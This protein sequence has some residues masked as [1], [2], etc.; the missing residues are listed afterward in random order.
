MARHFDLA[1]RIGALALALTVS[2]PAEAGGIRTTSG[3]RSGHLSSHQG[4][5]I[6]GRHA[7][8]LPNGVRIF[9]RASRAAPSRHGAVKPAPAKGRTGHA[10]THGRRDANARGGHRAPAGS[11]SGTGRGRSMQARADGVHGTGKRGKAK[12]GKHGNKHRHGHKGHR[13]KPVVYASTVQILDAG[14][15]PAYRETAEGD[16][17]R[18]LTDRGYDRA[19]RRV[20]VEWTVCFDEHGEPYMPPDGRRILARY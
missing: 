4:V 1:T 11:A 3:A 15:P 6:F 12:A 20:L 5:A 7:R 2:S 16:E 19:G 17:C 9:H 13:G 14:P 10:V 8:G 18:F